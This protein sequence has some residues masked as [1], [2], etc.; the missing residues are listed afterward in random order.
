MSV[1]LT[2]YARAMMGSGTTQLGGSAGFLQNAAIK[3]KAMS[4]VMTEQDIFKVIAIRA[5]RVTLLQ[6]LQQFEHA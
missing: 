5:S 1:P 2:P 4:N 3:R 6:L